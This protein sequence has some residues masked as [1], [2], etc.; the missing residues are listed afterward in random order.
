MTEQSKLA[1]QRAEITRLSREVAAL[2]DDLADIK[3]QRDELSGEVKRLRT[4]LQVIFTEYALYSGVSD[5]AKRMSEI[6][7]RALRG[8]QN[9]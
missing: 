2:R 1:K 8:D 3:A 4:A 5:I 6:A 9:D 7:G